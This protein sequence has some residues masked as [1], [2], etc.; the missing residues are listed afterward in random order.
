MGL[1]KIGLALILIGLAIKIPAVVIENN[2]L[3]SIGFGFSIAGVLIIGYVLLL[4][5]LN[6]S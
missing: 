6:K 5:K 4:N 2:Y 1:Y 3:F